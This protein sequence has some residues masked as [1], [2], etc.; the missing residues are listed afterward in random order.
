MPSSLVVP[1]LARTS[2][3]V[4]VLARVNGN[5]KLR[6]L[7]HTPKPFENV[8]APS[9]QRQPP[10]RLA[11]ILIIHYYISHSVFKNLAKL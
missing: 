8:L 6:V 5:A 2:V 9:F 1:T 10:Q 7:A 3:G 11:G 4:H